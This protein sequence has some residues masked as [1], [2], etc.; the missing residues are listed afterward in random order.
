MDELLKSIRGEQGANKK[1]GD[2]QSN[3]RVKEDRRKNA[4]GEQGHG[5]VGQHR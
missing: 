5:N 1:K 2:N 3:Q 4:G